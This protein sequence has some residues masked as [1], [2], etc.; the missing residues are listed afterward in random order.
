[1]AKAEERE[2]TMA[3]DKPRLSTLTY[4]GFSVNLAISHGHGR[5]ISFDE[6][7][8]SLDKGTILEDLDAEIPDE[9]DFS[10]FPVESEQSV[11]LNKAIN[12]IAGGL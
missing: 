11:A 9:F 6:I 10:L 8:E 4:L 1:M 12:Q 7:Y 5:S 2:I 3:D